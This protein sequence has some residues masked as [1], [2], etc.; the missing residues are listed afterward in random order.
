[1]RTQRV[2]Q[3]LEHSEG[4][5]GRIIVAQQPELIEQIGIAAV[6]VAQVE[7]L[8]MGDIERRWRG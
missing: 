7:V 2:D 6:G 5:F 1:L 4:W 3:H 8:V